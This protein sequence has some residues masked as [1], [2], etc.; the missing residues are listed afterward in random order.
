MNR[1]ITNTEIETVIRKTSNKVPGPDGLIGDF[2]QKFKEY[3]TNILF[4]LFQKIAEGKKK[5]LK[6]IL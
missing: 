2:Y 1:A 5:T 3:L 4:K 6:L